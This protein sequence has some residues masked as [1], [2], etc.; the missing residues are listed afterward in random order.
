MFDLTVQELLFSMAA[1]AFSAGLFTFWIGVF[2]LIN[3]SNNREMLAI[4]NQTT[5]IAKKGLAND[6]AG[7][8]GNASSLIAVLNDLIRTQNGIGGFL[9]VVGVILMITSA[10][11]ALYLFV[12]Q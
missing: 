4:A 8:V 6:L 12:N 10:G 1:I 5:Q 2:V 7:L 9:I 3:R 11:L